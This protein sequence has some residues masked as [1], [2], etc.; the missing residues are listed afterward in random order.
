[1]T[2]DAP[3]DETTATALSSYA[4][5]GLT[6]SGTPT[7]S[8]STVTLT[9]SP[10]SFQSYTVTVAG[11][12][13]ASDHAPLTTAVGMFTG[14]SAFNVVS[15]SA[16]TNRTIMV[17]FDAPP[18]PTAATSLANYSV[19]GLTLSGT[20][21][22]SGNSVTLQCSPQAVTAYMV[23][24]TGVRRA[25]D[26]EPLTSAVAMFTGRIDFNVTGAGPIDS[27]TI[28][29]TFDAPPDMTQAT[30]M[31]NYSVSG[32][33]S[34]TSAPTLVGSTVTISTSAQA[35]QTYTVTVTGVTRGNDAEPLTVNTA[36]FMGRTPFDVTGAAAQTTSQI[37]VTF[38]AAPLLAEATDP[39][40][41]DIPGLSLGAITLS[42][43]TVTIVTSLQSASTYMVT[44]TGV[45]RASDM[46][47]LT[48]SMTTFVGRPPFDVASAAAVTSHSITVTF[49]AAPN[50]AQATT[51]AN[52]S[53]SGLMLSGTPTL[54][55]NI[56][57]I[58]TT[59]QS[60]TQFTVTVS[61]I[62]RA[63]D[64][65]PLTVSTANFTG[66]APFDVQ[67][68]ASTSNTTITVTYDAAPNAAEATTLSNYSVNAGALGLTGVTLAGNV[69]TL[70][71]VPQTKTSYSVVVSGVTRQA[72]AEALTVATASFT[73]RAP[74]DVQSA[75]STSNITMTV[76]FDAPP[77]M[78]QA[79]N[80]NN[81]TVA[82]LALSGPVLLAGSVVTINTASQAVQPY[83][84]VV[85]G[86][87]RA[88]DAEALT[89]AS[90]VFTGRNGFNVA[91]AAS[92]GRTTMTVTFDAAP[93]MTA[94]TTVANYSVNPPL[95]LSAPVLAGNTVTLTTSTQAPGNYTV[96]VTGGAGGVTRASDGT[97]LSVNTAAFNHAAFDVA[98]AVSLSNTSIAV[99]FDAAPNA[100]TATTLT[101]Y[102]IPGLVLSGTPSLNGNTV[103]ITTAS[104]T[105]TSYTVTV[106]TNVTRNSDGEPLTV[107]TATFP[108]RP[109]FNVASAA[110]TGNGT[111]TVTFSDPPNPAQAQTLG[112]YSVSGG[113][114]LN[115]SP[116][117]SGN[118]VTLRTSQ[119]S[120]ISYTVTVTGVTRASD[121]EPLTTKTGTF[122]GIA[123]SRPTVTSVAV[124]STSPDNGT[125][126]YNTGTATVTITGTGFTFATA[127]TVNDIDGAG[128]PLN[129]PAMFTIVSDTQISA[130]FPAGIR[131][132]YTGWTVVV[133]N[134]AGGSTNTVTVVVKAG[135][136]I[137]EV[138]LNASSGSTQHEFVEVYNATGT[139][140]NVMTLGMSMHFFNSSGSGTDTNKP[141]TFINTTVQSHGFFLIVSAQSTSGDSWYAHRDA[142]YDASSFELNNDQGVN[143]SLSATVAAKVLDRVGWG[144]VRSSG[145]EGTAISNPSLGSFG[146][147]AQRKPVGSGG[148]HQTD[149]DSNSADINAFSAT[150]NPLGTV[151]TPK[152]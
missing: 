34:L 145:R 3:P 106:S 23:T 77:N 137:G 6:I 18:D 47:A 2:F 14:R 19:T 24:V 107:K 13:R 4:V 48:S 151:D 52:Y 122:T 44:V 127:V 144:N 43:N 111:M 63:S 92:T 8:G 83:T 72:D 138:L 58:T 42:G 116:V 124:S 17:T 148:G 9:T 140:L 60:A 10:Q 143:V 26:A 27:H 133:T 70:T 71:T 149:T 139:S 57:T 100:G 5:S 102:S 7:L 141:L 79:T 136:L 130:T 75:A 16:A 78:A 91:S 15:A 128:A 37:T 1:V 105:A 31:A 73:G 134:S 21:V 108:G 11:V 46:E 69:A 80:I 109:P 54:N 129:T 81:Y 76:T 22:L 98:S 131:S 41:Y 62:Q 121:G 40:N 89:T 74:F 119:Q 132:N 65:E 152:P 113:L 56:V 118:T 146:V 150:I 20:P 29:V 112:A 110:S 64:N 50:A 49:D 51:L 12:V 120:A 61:G 68:A 84:V 35:A 97:P 30:N 99:T 96:T 88:S 101:N 86:V 90:G 82:G 93:N 28:T 126:F 85:T 67:S 33:L 87:T 55:G 115:G 53:V 25:S 103:T 142:T 36:N 45:Q 114:T 59:P 38:D 125:T 117:L 95:T 39:M 123:A 66:R 135:L 104:Q 32:G 147:S 94:A